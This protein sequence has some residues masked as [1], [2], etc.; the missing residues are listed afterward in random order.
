MTKYKLSPKLDK[1]P[2]IAIGSYYDK[3]VQI[4]ILA[5]R[6]SGKL[7]AGECKYSKDEAKINMLTNLKAKCQQAKL[8]VDEYVLFA[9]NGFSSE[10]REYNDKNLTL[11]SQ[12]DL[13]TLLDNLNENDLL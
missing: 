1:D 13:S 3:K 12:D 5:K 6:R 2:I 7:I 4:G 10:L 8:E 9:K 11:F